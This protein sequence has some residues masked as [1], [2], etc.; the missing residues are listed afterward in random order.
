MS[1]ILNEVRALLLP[2]DDAQ[3]ALEVLVADEEKSNNPGSSDQ[4]HLLAVISHISSGSSQAGGHEEGSVFLLRRSPSERFEIQRVFPIFRDLSLNLAQSRRATLDLSA[5]AK[6][7][8]N[9][10]R[11]GFVLTL[12][13]GSQIP[14]LVLTA[15]D[16]HNLRPLLSECKRL[17]ELAL[18][19]STDQGAAYPW[20]LPY[21]LR[22]NT[23]PIMSHTPIDLRIL[24]KPLHERL[25]PASAGLPGDD[26]AD[27]TLIR[28][29]WVRQQ[30]RNA[31][32][33]GTH[34]LTLRV[35]TFNVNGKPPSEDLAAWIRGTESFASKLPP[36]EN[37][38]PLSIGLSERPHSDLQRAL[39]SNASS[40]DRDPDI[41]VFGFQELDL[42]TEALLYSTSTIKEDSW[43]AAIF[44][45]LGNKAPQYTKLASKQ[46][47]GMLIVIVV[48]ADLK[49]C[50]S[51]VRLSATGAGIMGVMGNKGGTAVRLAFTP[52][53][54]DKGSSGFRPTILTFVNTHL[55]AFDEMVDKRNM[56][57]HDLSKRLGFSSYTPVEAV[58]PPQTSIYE[59]DVL[60]W[61]VNLNYRIDLPDGEVRSILTTW[62]E[63]TRYRTLLRY[64]QLRNA[65][66][67]RRAFELFKEFA[68]NHHPSYRYGSGMTDELGY[69]LKR[70]PAWTDRILH[71]ASPSVHVKQLNYQVHPTVTLS[72]HRPVSAEFI[73]PIDVLPESEYHESVRRLL[74]QVAPTSPQEELRPIISVED[75][76]I[77]FGQIRYKQLASRTIRV[78][79]TG[80]VPCCWRFIPITPNEAI[81]PEWLRILPLNG[82][83]LPSE[84]ASINLEINIETKEAATL[85]LGPKVLGAALI[86]HTAFGKDHFISVGAEYQ[87]SCFANNLTRLTHLPG[88]V[89]SLKS[90]N[91]LLP[92]NRGVNAPREIMR[93]VDWLMKNSSS[94][95]QVVAQLREHLDTGTDFPHPVGDVDPAISRAFWDTLWEL[96]MSLTEPIVPFPL[97][98]RC[99]QMTSRDEAFEFL[100]ELTPAAVNVWISVTAFLQFLCQADSSDTARRVATMCF[101]ALL[102]DD[103][104]PQSTPISPLAKVNFILYFI[105]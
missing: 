102:P 36:L 95:P 57:F 6:P 37:L 66:A 32:H 17:Q 68:I 56:D 49:P 90:Q 54:Q 74:R 71:L 72:D 33:K 5:A 101:P 44:A 93:L 22:K 42:S 73:V 63:D 31:C 100:S 29:H 19:H 98:A 34:Q 45:S 3:V 87:Y 62:P 24:N 51:D 77:H 43:T 75:T 14:P 35:G 41:F 84:V 18:T 16:T 79:N 2:A 60:I 86:L 15:F 83:L 92:E 104:N 67:G 23:Q 39:S 38:S 52:P 50:F 27:I 82:L 55:A 61:M 1:E 58:N 69:D 64:D 20:L 30:A 26:A 94:D 96:I 12:Q 10:P 21:T 28:D 46:L 80:K 70:R 48:K 81:S 85:N 99:T 88:P 78:K 105:T 40:L 13:P 25:S 4:P 11:T 97:Q 8:S 76:S 65:I 89:R 103:P 53:A 7:V 59:S 91:D 9:Q 47:V